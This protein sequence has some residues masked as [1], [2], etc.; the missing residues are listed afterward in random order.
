MMLVTAQWANAF[1]ARSERLSIIKRV[2]TPNY[3][4]LVGLGLAVAAQALVMFGPLQGAFKV[5]E[6]STN[7][8][9]VS[10]GLPVL[11]VLATVEIHKIYA[12]LKVERNQ[13]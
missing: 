13:Y 3:K 7:H 5:S 4:L 1:N 2:R 6:L 9:L 10:I 11:A 8:L 12:R